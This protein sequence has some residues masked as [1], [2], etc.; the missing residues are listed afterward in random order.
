MNEEGEKASWCIKK[1]RK[2]D[3]MSRMKGRKTDL[4]RMVEE[5]ERERKTKR[6][7]KSGWE[8]KKETQSERDTVSERDRQRKR[9]WQWK[10]ERQRDLQS[11]RDGNNENMRKKG[12]GPTDATFAVEQK[13][14]YT[15][16]FFL[17]TSWFFLLSV[18]EETKTKTKMSKCLILS[19]LICGKKG[20][21]DGERETWKAA[22]LKWSCD[23]LLLR[24]RRNNCST[25]QLTERTHFAKKDNDLV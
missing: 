7:R 19:L 9:H 8:T 15:N 6:E 13:F 5:W 3:W 23:Y 2:K 24:C 14:N 16:S 21:G 4:K 12:N 25:W 11:E 1:E 18:S 17:P 10:K 22:R 20:G